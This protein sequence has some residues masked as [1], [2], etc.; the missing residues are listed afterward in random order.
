MKSLTPTIIK[1]VAFAAIIG[2]LTYVIIAILQPSSDGP[3][4]ER[5]A[6]FSDASGLKPRDGVRLAGVKVGYVTAIDLKGP[7]AVVHFQLNDDVTITSN[8][9]AAVRY[10]NLLG[11]RY[12]E[13][14]G[15]AQ[16]MTQRAL[17]QVA[18]DKTIP[19]FDVSTLFNGFKPV[20]DTLNADE[21]NELQSNLLR[22]A[23]GDGRGIAPVLK[24]I[25]NIT[26][27]GNQRSEIITNIVTSLGQVSDQLEGRSAEMVELVDKLGS[28]VDAFSRVSDRLR[29]SLRE[30]NR[31]MSKTVITG[32][33]LE[34]TYDQSFATIYQRLAREPGELEGLLNG[35]V[36]LKPLMDSLAAA[37]NSTPSE[38][39][40]SKGL[41]PLPDTAQIALMG[42]R[43]VVCK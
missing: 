37:T 31:S 39:R 41:L 19:S 3:S 34:S 38:A 15:A 28:I 18:L 9:T 30:V 42:Q 13:L 33:Q 23:Q 2:V 21:I 14:I 6:V 17:T 32:E 10:Q 5:S 35:A 29:E 24:Q 1:I 22:V 4:S 43:L 27:Y 11:Q 12:V 16:G 7:T 20:F 36:L 25:A 8:T 40:C 26:A